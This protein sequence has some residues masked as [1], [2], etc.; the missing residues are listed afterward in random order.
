[1]V[2]WDVSLCYCDKACKTALAGKQVIVTVESDGVAY[3]IT[4]SKQTANP[5][6]EESHVDFGREPVGVRLE[7]L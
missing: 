3:G 5:I 1:M 7:T 4:D 6:E 2:Q